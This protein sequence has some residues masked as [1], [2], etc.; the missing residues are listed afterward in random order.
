M[1]SAK[2]DDGTPWNRGTEPDQNPET[3][4]TLTT[5]KYALQGLVGGYGDPTVT[6]DEYLMF[7]FPVTV[8]FPD[9]PNV[10]ETADTQ[11]RPSAYVGFESAVGMQL[12]LLPMSGGASL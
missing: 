3:I 2:A 5:K 1:T 8:E 10:R 12:N 9:D 6:W 4:K 7:Y 11:L